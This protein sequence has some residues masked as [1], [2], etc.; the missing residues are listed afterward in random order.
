MTLTD[1]LLLGFIGLTVYIVGFT[2]VYIIYG[3]HRKIIERIEADKNKTTPYD[4][5]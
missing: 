3:R 5:K 4:F 2:L 1:G